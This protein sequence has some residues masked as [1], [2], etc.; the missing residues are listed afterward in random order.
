MASSMTAIGFLVLHTTHN[1]LLLEETLQF[2][3]W[4]LRKR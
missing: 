1:M 4:L 2:K 3:S